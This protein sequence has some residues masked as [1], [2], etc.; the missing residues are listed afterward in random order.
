MGRNEG[1]TMDPPSASPPP[2]SRPPRDPPRSLHLQR[3]EREAFYTLLEDSVVQQFLSTDVCYRI[4][5]KYLLAMVLTYFKRAALPTAEYTRINL[6]TALYLAND[7]GRRRGEHKR[8][9]LACRA[10]APALPRL[11][12]SSQAYV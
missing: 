10:M 4:S 8:S 7:M 9:S 1:T 6:F 3:H 5:D 12:S 2:P 11:L